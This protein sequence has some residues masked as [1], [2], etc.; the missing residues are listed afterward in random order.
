MTV[1]VVGATGATGQLLVEQ[2]LN[3]GQKIKVIVQSPE[4]LLIIY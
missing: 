1:L 4:K 3:D 2:L